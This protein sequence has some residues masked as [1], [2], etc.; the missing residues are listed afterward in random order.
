MKHTRI[1]DYIQDM[2]DDA[3]ISWENTTYAIDALMESGKLSLSK[4]RTLKKQLNIIKIE[5]REKFA[6]ILRILK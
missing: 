5:N 1:E 3:E 4:G 2:I 6:E